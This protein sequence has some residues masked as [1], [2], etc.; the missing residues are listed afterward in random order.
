MINRHRRQRL[1]R[2]NLNELQLFVGHVML[3]RVK[4]HRANVRRSWLKEIA[5]QR[6]VI[7]YVAQSAGARNKSQQRR[8]TIRQLKVLCSTMAIPFTILRPAAT[9]LLA[10]PWTD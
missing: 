4:D 8:Q 1:G 9:C 2:R 10:N 7:L 5:K 6:Q 3:Q